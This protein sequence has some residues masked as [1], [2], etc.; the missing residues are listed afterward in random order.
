MKLPA[1]VLPLALSVCVFGPASMQ[2]APAPIAAPAARAVA[3]FIA[4]ENFADFRDSL[5]D[6]EKARQQLGDE[7]A[8]HVADIGRRYIPEGQRLEI[9]FTNIDLAGDF[10]PWRGPNFDDIRIVKEIYPPRM[11]F[12]YRL[13]DAAT[14]AVIR[15]GS[16][17][18][19]DLAYLMSAGRLPS[20]DQL[21]H[22]KQMLS[23][24]MRREFKRTTK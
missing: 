10:E 16:E 20:H 17:K 11:E 7:I 6:T 8:G 15:Q 24:W 1:V 9:R 14:G 21:R 23:D 5:F 22:D 13:V 3:E 19:V 18:L 4:P 12:D 2:G